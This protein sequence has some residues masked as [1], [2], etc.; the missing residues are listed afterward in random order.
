MGYIQRNGKYYRDDT[1]I[2][3]AE[4]TAGLELISRAKDI[5]RRIRAGETLEVPEELRDIVTEQL[6]AWEAYDREVTDDPEPEELLNILLGGD[7][8]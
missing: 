6:E 8:E 2:T 3:E 1:E 4:Y 5:T 7:T